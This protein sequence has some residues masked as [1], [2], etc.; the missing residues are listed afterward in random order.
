MIHYTN[1]KNIDKICY[2]ID[3]NNKKIEN[4]KL[5]KLNDEILTSKS[6]KITKPLRSFKKSIK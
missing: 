5:N 4:D 3:K 2:D 6:W 1:I